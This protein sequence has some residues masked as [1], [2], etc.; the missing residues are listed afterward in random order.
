VETAGPGGRIEKRQLRQ[1]FRREQE[2][3]DK[4]LNLY[5]ISTENLKDFIIKQCEWWYWNRKRSHENLIEEYK[6]NIS[7]SIDMYCAITGMN[8]QDVVTLIGRRNGHNSPTLKVIFPD[9]VEEQR[10]LATRSLKPWVDRVFSNL[11]PAFSFSEQNISQFFDWLEDR[12]LYNFFWH[13]HRL[14]ELESRGGLVER[15]ASS[16]EVVSFSTLVEMIA[17]EAIIERGGMPRGKTLN[18]KLRIIFDASGPFNVQNYFN[19]FSHLMRTD[20][21]TLSQ[22]IAKIERIK[23]GGVYNPIVKALISAVVIRN[24]GAHLGLLRYDRSKNIELLQTLT[25]AAL[26]IWKAR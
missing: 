18:S 2:I 9:W 22:Q 10:Q 11:P 3:A 25:L 15:A 20:N 19:K 17:N 13:Y 26:L 5:K 21:Y 14:Y 23:A 12:G 1:F 7:A 8:F 4:S 6:R 24:E 16:S